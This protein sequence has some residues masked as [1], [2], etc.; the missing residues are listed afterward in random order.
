MKSVLV[1]LLL[2]LIEPDEW[3]FH[4]VHFVSNPASQFVVDGHFIHQA[5]ELMQIDFMQT[6]TF[7]VILDHF[8]FH[9]HAFHYLDFDWLQQIVVERYLVLVH[10]DN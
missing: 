10:F 3:F 7:T 2:V 4:N 8:Y 5:N 6:Q 1:I 9:V